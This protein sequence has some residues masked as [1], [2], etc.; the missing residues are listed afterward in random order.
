[1]NILEDTDLTDQEKED[2]MVNADGTEAVNMVDELE[3]MQYAVDNQLPFIVFPA[4]DV[5]HFMALRRMRDKLLIKMMAHFN[6][7]SSTQIN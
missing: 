3:V 6:N 4:Q 7:E 5:I 1:M 2:I